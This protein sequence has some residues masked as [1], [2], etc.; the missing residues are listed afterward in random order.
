[1]ALAFGILIISN[2]F[3]TPLEL[4][5]SASFVADAAAPCGLFASGVL[6]AR[7]ISRNSLKLASVITSLKMLIHPL[8]GFLIINIAGGYAV[9]EARTTLMVTVA[10]VGV[11]ALT[12][13]SQYNGE[14]DAIAQSIVWSFFL[15]ILLIPIFAVI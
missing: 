4:V 5:R 9:E 3:G 7:P 12:F 14:T 8:L 1:M 15:S 10:P 11:M 6:L 13:A 2:P